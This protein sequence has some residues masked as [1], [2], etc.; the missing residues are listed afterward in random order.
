MDFDAFFHHVD[1]VRTG[2]LNAFTERY[3]KWCKRH[4]CN[5]RQE[6][7]ERI[8]NSSKGLIAMLPKDTMTKMLVSQAIDM[9][10]AVS[11]TVE[12]LRQEMN[13]LAS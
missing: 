1:C 12:N 7:A 5:F 3:R 8:Y 9:L 6:K 10:N 2:S 11:K 13:R 4:G